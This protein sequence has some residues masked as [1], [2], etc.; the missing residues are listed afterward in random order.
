[1]A[2]AF[3]CDCCGEFFIHEKRNY[4]VSFI[5]QS[6]IGVESNETFDLCENCFRTMHKMFE[7]EEE[8]Q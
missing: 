5:E 7:K 4:W 2:A 3:Q 6:Q 8:E 1:M